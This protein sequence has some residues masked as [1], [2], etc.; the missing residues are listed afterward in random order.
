MATAWYID[1]FYNRTVLAGFKWLA[2]FF[3]RVFD[4]QGVDGLVGGVTTLVGWGAG[5][6][7]RM[8]SG[9]VRAYALF[10]TIGVVIVLGYMV[11][12]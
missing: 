12:R 9:Y 5:A 2:R 7:R 4:P 10:F 3:A 6:V 11:L 8:Q 1:S